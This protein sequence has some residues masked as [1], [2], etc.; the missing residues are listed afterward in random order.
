M[1]KADMIKDII[2]I[3][4]WTKDNSNYYKKV[5]A[6]LGK[7]IWYE[8]NSLMSRV[9]GRVKKENLQAIHHDVIEAIY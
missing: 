9:L 8:S 6:A 5:D 3:L 7:I 4:N 1:K 2:E